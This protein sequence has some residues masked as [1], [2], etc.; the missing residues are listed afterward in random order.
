MSKT[1]KV[2]VSLFDKNIAQEVAAKLTSRYS[3]THLEFEFQTDGPRALGGGNNNGGPGG[4]NGPGNMQGENTNGG[5]GGNNGPGNMQ[6]GN[7]NGGPGGNN[8]PGNMQGGNGKPVDCG[9]ATEK[10]KSGADKCLKIANQPK[11]KACFDKIGDQL[12]KKGATESCGDALDKL[13]QEVL[14]QESA[15]YPNDP[16]SIN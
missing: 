16:P 3:Q 6:G 5:P 9:K 1:I 15:S 12:H 8:G 4:N 2:L 7:N 13:K 11:R 10:A 14:K